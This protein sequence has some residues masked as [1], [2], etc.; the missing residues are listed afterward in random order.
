MKKIMKCYRCKK[1]INPK[2]KYVRLQTLDLGKV[3]EDLVFHG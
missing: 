2:E 1:A 3:K